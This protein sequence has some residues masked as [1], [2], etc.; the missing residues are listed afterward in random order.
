MRKL[1]LKK[2]ST[3]RLPRATIASSF[4]R[5]SAP[6]FHVLTQY[7]ARDSSTCHTRGRHTHGNGRR[8]RSDRTVARHAAQ[9]FQTSAR[10]RAQEPQFTAQ[11]KAHHSL[12]VQADCPVTPTWSLGA[13]QCL[14]YLPKIIRN[15]C[16]GWPTFLS[17]MITH[18]S[19][20][21][22][23]GAASWV[24]LGWS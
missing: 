5:T 23:L 21:Q 13:K 22:D 17:T 3:L 16:T 9:A 18:N 12:P 11:K 4:C 10:K 20:V 15:G 1:W 6:C 7:T 24:G 8:R 19:R 2:E 14:Y